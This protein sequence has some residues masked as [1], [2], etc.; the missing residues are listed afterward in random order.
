M[1]TKMESNFNIIAESSN[2]LKIKFLKELGE[3]D[4][5]DIIILSSQLEPEFG[6]GAILTHSNI[7]KYFN[8]NT[9]PFIA[10]INNK[11][12]GFIVGVPLENF[13][14]ESWSHYDTNLGKKNTIYTYIYLVKDFYRKQGGYSK[15]LKMIYLNWCRKNN[16]TY[17][18]GHV[19]VGIA[20][21]FQD[22]TKIVKI[23]PKWYNSDSPFE[24][25]RRKL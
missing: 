5:E 16:Y 10:E 15:T 1:T 2:G 19:K 22:E 17:V 3:R 4:K 13:S 8:K 21:K 11:I 9:F 24:Y 25:Y 14:E 6:S 23:F 12:I 18:T 20:K 7:D